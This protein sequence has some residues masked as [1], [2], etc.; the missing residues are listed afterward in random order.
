MKCFRRISERDIVHFAQLLHHLLPLA[1]QFNLDTGECL[2]IIQ[3]VFGI[4]FS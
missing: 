2:R 1:V 4:I 3:L